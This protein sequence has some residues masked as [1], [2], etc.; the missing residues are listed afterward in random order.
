MWFGEP[1]RLAKEV[2]LPD[3]ARRDKQGTK[4][5][6]V[7]D[8]GLPF[9]IGSGPSRTGTCFSPSISVLPYQY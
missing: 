6:R 5:D 4:D 1:H 9:G 3:W 7:Q 2:L 8:P